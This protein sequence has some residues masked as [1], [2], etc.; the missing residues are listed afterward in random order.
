MIINEM[1]ADNAQT[2]NALNKQLKS[3]YGV[4]INESVSEAEL[5]KLQKTSKKIINEMKMNNTSINNS[6]K[7]SMYV[8]INEA[9]DARLPQLVSDKQ[10]KIKQEVV[11]SLV[12]MIE[13][14][15]KM[16]CKL[17]AC[18]EAAMKSY[19]SSGYLFKGEEIKSMIEYKLNTLAQVELS[20]YHKEE[21][22]HSDENYDKGQATMNQNMSASIVGEMKKELETDPKFKLNESEVEEAEIIIATKGFSKSLQEMIEKVGRLQNEDLPPLTDQMRSNFGNESAIMFHEKTQGTLQSVLDALYYSKEEIDRVVQDMATGKMEWQTDLEGEMDTDM[23]MNM[24]MDMNP[25]N[26]EQ[27]LGDELI[28]PDLDVEPEVSDEEPLGRIRKES[29]QQLYKKMKVIEARLAK[30]NKS[31]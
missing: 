18:I 29:V 12:A 17:D 24:D 21:N 1:K 20:E 13:H 8:L 19:Y 26:Q 7:Y 9:I 25:E 15:L 23:N 3:I 10:N 30:A 31:K 14:N 11:D 27:E 16:G 5:L 4:S 22:H 28:D 2:F 6:K